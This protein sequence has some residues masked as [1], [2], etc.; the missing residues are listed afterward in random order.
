MTN[1]EKMNDLVKKVDAFTSTYEMTDKQAEKFTAVRD[2]ILAKIPEIKE[3]ETRLT[4]SQEN[5]A[6]FNKVAEWTVAI[7][8]GLAISYDH[9]L[10]TLLTMRIFNRGVSKEANINRYKEIYADI[11]AKDEKTGDKF[12]KGAEALLEKLDKH[13]TDI[14]QVGILSYEASLQAIEVCKSNGLVFQKQGTQAK[15]SKIKGKK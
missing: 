5:G 13:L 2:G 6:A 7:E 1:T 8:N 15:L 12:K 3:I 11:A 4:K 10:D 14:E 9:V